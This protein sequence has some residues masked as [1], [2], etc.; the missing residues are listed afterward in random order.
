[1]NKQVGRGVK[2]NKWNVYDLNYKKRSGG[3]KRKHLKILGG[4]SAIREIEE[5]KYP[6]FSHFQQW[7]GRKRRRLWDFLAKLRKNFE[8]KWD[9]GLLKP[10]NIKKPKDWEH[11]WKKKVEEKKEC[12]GRHLKEE[13]E[14]RKT[15]WFHKLLG[16]WTPLGMMFLLCI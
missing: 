13:R 10:S 1:M 8:I 4:L 7:W 11:Y 15:F 16:S 14:E 3:V 12:F 6:S 2:L 9:W 5:Y